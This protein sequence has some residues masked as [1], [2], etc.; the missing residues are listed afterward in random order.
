MI[1]LM[2]YCAI[3]P[4]SIIHFHPSDMILYVNI[5]AAYLIT[6][7]TKSRT[8]GYYFLSSDPSKT[9]IPS[10]APFHILCR[11]FKQLV[12]SADKAKTAVVFFNAQESI[13]IQRLLIALDHPQSPSPLTIDN[14][15]LLT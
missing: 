1:M 2:Y 10:D 9:H 8:A 11:F 14:L 5:D 3:Y 4:F 15:H 6:S 13:F 7:S 12:D